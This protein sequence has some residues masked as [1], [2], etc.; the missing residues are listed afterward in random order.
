MNL[1]FTSTFTSNLSW[2]YLIHQSGIRAEGNRQ[3]VTAGMS[4]GEHGPGGQT[5]AAFPCAGEESV[6]HAE[7]GFIFGAECRPWAHPV[8]TMTLGE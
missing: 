6:F 2:F 5:P 8:L 4:P 1:F 3:L 7:C